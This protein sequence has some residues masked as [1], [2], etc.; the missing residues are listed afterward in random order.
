[1]ANP[2]VDLQVHYLII[3]ERRT[4]RYRRVLSSF[5]SKES[6]MRFMAPRIKAELDY[7]EHCLRYVPGSSIHEYVAECRA[8]LQREELGKAFHL[9][10]T[11]PLLTMSENSWALTKIAHH[12]T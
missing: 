5:L 9:L 4:D 11:S 6:A 2:N 8:A 10:T 7:I 3:G 12:P 1:M